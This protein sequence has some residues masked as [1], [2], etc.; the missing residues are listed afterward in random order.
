MEHRERMPRS[1]LPLVVPACLERI[2]IVLVE[3]RTPGNIG[4]TARAMKTMG[5][6][7]LTLVS[8]AP[9]RE[10]GE[11][12]P[13]A[14]LPAE[15]GGASS[16]E[17]VA[18]GEQAAAFA[19]A[20]AHGAEEILEGAEVVGELSAACAG[21]HLLVGTTNKRRSRVLPD[22]TPAREAAARIAEVAQT[23]EV[24][25]LFGRE[26]AGLST[27]ELSLCQLCVTIPAARELPSLNLSHAV[28]VLA[29]EIFLAALGAVP[30]PAPDL[31][32]VV[33]LEALYE[34]TVRLMLRAGFAPHEEDPETFVAS[35]RRALGR[36]ALEKR[37]VRTLH[38]VLGSLEKI[39][40][41]REG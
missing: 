33:E 10:E 40:P 21:A 12:R 23:H 5:L 14:S 29:Y 24:A 41:E 15:A 16:E 8:P 34:R 36:A 30:R 11:A 31:A 2:R 38:R 6:S 39:A 1:P 20:L 37:D 9:F 27:R 7:R 4:A 22:P 28:Q 19:R 13:A 3:P 26:D 35:L 18:G 25:V 32:G 17:V